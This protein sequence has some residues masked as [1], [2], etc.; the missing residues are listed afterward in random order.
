MIINIY[1]IIQ[2]RLFYLPLWASVLVDL[3]KITAK[4]Y[5]NGY[6]TSVNMSTDLKIHKNWCSTIIEETTFL[7]QQYNSIL[8]LK[9][10]SFNTYYVRLSFCIAKRIFF[11]VKSNLSHGI[12]TK[13]MHVCFLS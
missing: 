3:V 9:D 4:H 11:L 1:K 5:V 2:I 6:C 10:S 7:S 12:K 13:R 8:V